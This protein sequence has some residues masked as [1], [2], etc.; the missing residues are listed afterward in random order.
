MVTLLSNSYT[1]FSATKFVAENLVY[2]LDNWNF[3]NLQY[4]NVSVKYLQLVFMIHKFYNSFR[5]AERIDVYVVW[6]LV[7]KNRWICHAYIIPISQIAKFMGP[8]WGPPGSCRPQIGPMLA[9]WTLLSGML[10]LDIVLRKDNS[11]DVICQSIEE[12]YTRNPI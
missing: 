11:Y 9:P 6:V 5:M 10:M 3:C 4:R 1:R 12:M 2:E 8:T 7:I